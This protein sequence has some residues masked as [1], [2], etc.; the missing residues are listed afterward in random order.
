MDY[1]KQQEK[2]DFRKLSFF[3]CN[4]SLIFIINYTI[5]HSLHI[6]EHNILP[7]LKLILRVF[8]FILTL[9]FT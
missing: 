8:F 2:N 4:F 1:Q 3:V 5:T 9:T 6:S 7:L